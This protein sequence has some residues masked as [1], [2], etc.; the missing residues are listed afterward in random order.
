M[1]F[2]YIVG[3]MGISI[4]YREEVLPLGRGGLITS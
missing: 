3:S 4:D 1:W 2:K